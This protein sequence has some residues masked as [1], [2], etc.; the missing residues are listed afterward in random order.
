MNRDANLSNDEIYCQVSIRFQTT[1]LPTD[2][3][4]R[5]NTNEKESIEFSTEAYNYQTHD[6]N[7]PKNCI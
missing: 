6:K 3:P 1:F 5:N 4:F 2:S 7:N